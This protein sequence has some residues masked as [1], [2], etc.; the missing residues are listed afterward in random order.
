VTKREK[1]IAGKA[2]AEIYDY[3]GFEAIIEHSHGYS[4]YIS[5]EAASALRE[6]NEDGEEIENYMNIILAKNFAKFAGG[7]FVPKGKK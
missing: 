4:D 6:N 3:A 1:K 7:K 2:L 5:K